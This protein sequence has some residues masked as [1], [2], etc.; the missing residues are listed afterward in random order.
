MQQPSLEEFRKLAGQSGLVPVYREIIADLDTP[1]TIFAK[2]AGGKSHAF[3]LES[4]EGG[5]E[6]G[7][8]SF[9]GLDPLVT[10]ES[11]GKEITIRWPGKKEEQKG[12]PIEALKQLLASFNA[13]NTDY[14]PRFFGGAV[15]FMGYD[16]VRFMER[17]PDLTPRLQAFPDSSL[18]VP[19]TVLIYDNLKQTLAIVHCV[20]IDAGLPA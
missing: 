8:Y 13:C 7:R 12:D 20:R 11:V 16:M 17:L 15:G 5:E 10:M 3:L 9:I 4:L 14:L 6:W 2:V 19:S 1:L 18:M